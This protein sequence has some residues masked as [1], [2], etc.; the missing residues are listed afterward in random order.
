M[1]DVAP[2]TA[3]VDP[4]TSTLRPL[5]DA[6]LTVRIIKSFEYRTTKNLILP[7][8]DLTTMTVGALKDFLRKGKFLFLRKATPRLIAPVGRDPNCFWLQTFPN[9]CPRCAASFP[10]VRTPLMRGC[11]YDQA[12]HES[13]RIQGE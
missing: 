8:V 5:D 4:L 12:V 7:H 6:V 2:S 9:S 1:D 11:R 10:P 13:A 3:T